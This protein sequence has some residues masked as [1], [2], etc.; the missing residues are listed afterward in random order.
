MSTPKNILLARFPET[1]PRPF[2]ITHVFIGLFIALFL[3]F[4]KPFGLDNVR[5]GLLRICLTFGAITT[6]IGV[7]YDLVWYLLRRKRGVFQIT[8]IG[9]AL[10]ALTLVFLIALGNFI[11]VNILSG[12]NENTVHH[13][14]QMM[15]NTI[16]IAVFPVFFSAFIRFNRLKAYY[17]H[18]AQ[19]VAERIHKV[20][21]QP[22]KV[23][24]QKGQTDEV[25]IDPD[26]LYAV[27]AMENYALLRHY[28]GDKT[29][30]TTLRATMKSL[31]EELPPSF[32][33]VHR[34][35]YANLDKI[36]KVEGNAAGLNLILGPYEVPVS[37]GNIQE[38]QDKMD[39]R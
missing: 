7:V 16:G 22:Y 39:R 36:D 34:S 18:E 38:L 5:D 29:W 19:K 14:G 31:E 9:W 26:E 32:M 33:R 2:H 27:E 1:E 21:P 15:L 13:L 10:H 12:W 24:L 28:D 30:T 3:W 6:G 4:F 35:Y 17:R 8:F 23:V 25:I 11:Y 37:R 20:V